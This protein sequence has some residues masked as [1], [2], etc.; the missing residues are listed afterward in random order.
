MA[1]FRNVR[2]DKR[3][4]SNWSR[5]IMNSR[6]FAF[7]ALV[8]ALPI[9]A[10]TGWSAPILIAPGVHA[11]SRTVRAGLVSAGRGDEQ[12][13]GGPVRVAG[14][15]TRLNLWKVLGPYQYS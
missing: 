15:V 14:G 10:S 8:S 3:V 1:G 11:E 2:K 4:I 12:M 7:A 5:T 6:A 9:A 13:R